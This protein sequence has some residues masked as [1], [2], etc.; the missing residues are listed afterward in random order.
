M[1][2]VFVT[3]ARN[4]DVFTRY[5][6]AENW[7]VT[8]KAHK[9]GSLLATAEWKR[10]RSILRCLGAVYYLDNIPWG[11]SGKEYDELRTADHY[12]P[13][14]SGGCAECPVRL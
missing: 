7:N 2:R 5:D 14:R 9:P 13:Q 1:W 3:F 6:I 10:S 8:I 12:H 4:E 11:P